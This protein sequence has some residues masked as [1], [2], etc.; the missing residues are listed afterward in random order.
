MRRPFR[1]FCEEQ[2]PTYGRLS[3]E[4]RSYFLPNCSDALSAD[5]RFIP[6]PA[7]HET[8]LEPVR[9]F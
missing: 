6:L 4:R 8:G 3:N 5:E 9:P 7:L 2:F 1:D